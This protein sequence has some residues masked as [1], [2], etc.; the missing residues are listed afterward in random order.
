[1][2]SYLKK[3]ISEGENQKLDFKYCVSNCKKIARTLS[4]FAN[5]DGGR[6]LIGV[7]DNGSIAGIQTDEEFY[8]IDTAARLFCRPEIPVSIKQHMAGGK[9][10][11]EVEVIK[12]NNKPY[13]AKDE[14]GKWLP[15]FRHHDQNLVA[16]KVL[17]QVWRKKENRSGVLIRFGKA[18][19]SLFDY[20]W[21]N[22]SITLSGFRKIARIPVY[23][24]E[25]IIGEPYYLQSNNYECLRKRIQI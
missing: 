1:M 7:R 12:G 4:A 15:Y 5:S 20:L 24:A 11:L 9:T 17:L 21:K 16:N 23:R 25:K 10:I 14:D 6:L 3:L 2:D 19:N 8:M 13:L 18:E 22:G